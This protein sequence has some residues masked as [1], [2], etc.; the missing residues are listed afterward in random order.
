MA[1]SVREHL[2]DFHTHKAEHH[3]NMAKAHE[4]LASHFQ[5]PAGTEGDQSDLHKSLSESFLK[6]A[7]HHAETAEYHVDAAKALSAALDG[8]AAGVSDSDLDKIV[9]DHV[10][11]II[12]ED[13]PLRAIPRYG[14]PE[15]IDTKGVAPEFQKFVEVEG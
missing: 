1:Q 6:L 14:Q 9:P 10:R 15:L 8:K 13:S 7:D 4:A 5:Q 3:T 2:R 12:P 11:G